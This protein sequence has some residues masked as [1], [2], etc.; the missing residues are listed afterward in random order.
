DKT[1][2]PLRKCYV[3]SSSAAWR[4]QLRRTAK[5]SAT[6][7]VNLASISAPTGTKMPGNRPWFTQ[8]DLAGG[9]PSWTWAPMR[10]ISVL[11]PVEKVMVTIGNAAGIYPDVDDHGIA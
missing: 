4:A 5:C 7:S 10:F 6:T 2:H 8:P 11:G 9:G 1:R 3:G